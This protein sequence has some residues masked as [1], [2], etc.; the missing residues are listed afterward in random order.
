MWGSAQQKDGT[1]N[2]ATAPRIIASSIPNAHATISDNEG[3]TV[4]GGGPFSTSPARSVIQAMRATKETD[5]A[6]TYYGYYGYLYDEERQRWRLYTAGQ[7]GANKGHLLAGG[8][9]MQENVTVSGAGSFVEVPGPFGV[10]MSGDV[11][12]KM[13]RRIWFYGSDGKFHP[14]QF[15]NNKDAT[16]EPNEEIANRQD[17]RTVHNQGAFHAPDYEKSGS[18]INTMGGMAHYKVGVQPREKADPA[19]RV[20]PVYLQPEKAKGLFELPVKFGGN[21]ASKISATGATIDYHIEST[22]PNSKAI[23]YYGAADSN[24]HI[25]S[26]T[27]VEETKRNTAKLGMLN[28]GWKT[29][30][31]KQEVKAGLNQFQLRDLDP[32]T[33]YYYRLYVEHDEGK[34]WDYVSG[35][36]KTQ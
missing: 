14:R 13:A 21:K 6:R 27:D 33:T 2:M 30:T 35:S 4:R 8:G 11:E 9:E 24:A 29:W 36:F 18:I 16:E 23:L 12:R 31:E 32:N 3:T 25:A 7:L 34:S 22:G 5:G 19:A 17:V 28:N 26:P 10:E 20:L 1:V 15:E